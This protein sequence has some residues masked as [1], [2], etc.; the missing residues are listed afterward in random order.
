MPTVRDL[1]VMSSGA[2]YSHATVAC[3]R[4]TRVLC[5]NPPL[6]RSRRFR[7]P[8]SGTYTHMMATLA[9]GQD[10]TVLTCSAGLRS[11]AHVSSMFGFT[12]LATNRPNTT[13]QFSGPQHALFRLV[14]QS[15]LFEGTLSFSH[16]ISSPVEQ[17]P[18]SRQ[19][20]GVRIAAARTAELAP[21]STPA[22]IRDNRPRWL[23]PSPSQC[24]ALACSACSGHAVVTCCPHPSPGGPCL[25]CLAAASG[26][27]SACRVVSPA[28]GGVLP[29][30]Q[31]GKGPQNP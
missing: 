1:S 3:C 10:Q 23:N 9:Q 12:R 29:D 4:P 8:Y 26:G 13:W 6:S 5:C 2:F 24:A 17:P 21:L 16:T 20:D 15:L 27:C 14:T 28:R 19:H 18:P 25:A 31:P 7:P 11:A 30:K 22:S